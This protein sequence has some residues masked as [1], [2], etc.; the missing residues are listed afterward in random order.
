[1][2]SVTR[3]ANRCETPSPAPSNTDSQ[4]AT[5]AGCTAP[6]ECDSD[7][8]ASE[9]YRAGQRARRQFSDGWPC[10][11]P[12]YLSEGGAS[13]AAAAGAAT[14]E[15]HFGRAQGLGPAGVPLRHDL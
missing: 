12:G 6:Y 1:M 3:G 11:P 10:V 9:M 8:I 2:G 14:H 7:A 13:A 15:L 5:R 4:M